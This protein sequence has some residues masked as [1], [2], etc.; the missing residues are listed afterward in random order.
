M[1]VPDATNRMSKE[2]TQLLAIRDA[3]I[4]AL[5][6][7]CRE[8]EQEVTDTNKYF[9]GACECRL[10][11]TTDEQ[12]DTCDFHRD[13]NKRIAELEAER[14]QWRQ[15]GSIV[16]VII[17]DDEG[18][19]WRWNGQDWADY[20]LETACEPICKA[21]GKPWP[22]YLTTKGPHGCSE[23]NRSVKP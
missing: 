10:D 7:R 9:R 1:K 15:R 23:A 14:G 18:K 22:D 4:A 17:R 6:A 11:E 2:L 3:R 8:A 21:C 12:R 13:Q 19:D 20:A 16:G 5:E